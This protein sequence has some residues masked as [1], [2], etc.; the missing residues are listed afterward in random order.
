LG[1]LAQKTRD[2][3]S[4]IADH[5]LETAQ[6]MLRQLA[7]AAREAVGLMQNGHKAKKPA[8]RQKAK[9]RSNGS[10]R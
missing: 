4:K 2:K 3:T 9:R 10:R 1:S 7:A 8:V 6:Q 5:D